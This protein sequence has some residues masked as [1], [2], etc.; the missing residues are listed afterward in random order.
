LNGAHKMSELGTERPD[1][2]E[3][4]ERCVSTIS[5]R[6]ESPDDGSDA[7][8]PRID[9]DERPANQS[10]EWQTQINGYGNY[11][12][13]SARVTRQITL[14]QAAADATLAAF[15]QMAKDRRQKLLWIAQRITR[16]RDEAEDIVQEALMRAFK[17]L[18]QFRGESQMA[19]WLGVIVLNAFQLPTIRGGFR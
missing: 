8:L 11:E 1:T 7:S 19:T 18:P 14:C 12:I 16:N 4:E 9:L 6:T 15:V 17:N 10:H 2:A 13:S 3:K 5:V